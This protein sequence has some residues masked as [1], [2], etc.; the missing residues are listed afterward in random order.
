MQI[1][2]DCRKPHVEQVRKEWQ[3]VPLCWLKPAVNFDNNV[4][5]VAAI[6]IYVNGM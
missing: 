6:L 4:K 3:F 1:E 2:S 5:V